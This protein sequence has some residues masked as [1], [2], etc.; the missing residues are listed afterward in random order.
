MAKKLESL[1]GDHVIKS[2]NNSEVKIQVTSLCGKD[3]IV[4]IYFSAEW[5]P[6]CK[7]FTPL[8]TD[9]YKK[10]KESDLKLEIVFVSWDKDVNAFKEYFS[11]MPWLAMPY[12]PERKVGM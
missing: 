6:P 9:F 1:L 10:I 5:C 4:A 3:R 8:L 11:H 12:S 2:E 7:S